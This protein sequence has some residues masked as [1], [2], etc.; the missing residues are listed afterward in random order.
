MSESSKSWVQNE[1]DGEAYHEMASAAV[2]LQFIFVRRGMLSATRSVRDIDT[3][4]R[5][6]FLY[7]IPV[8][9]Q[10]NDAPPF[11]AP[12]IE[13]P[14]KIKARIPS[15]SGSK[16]AILV[17]ENIPSNG[18][19]SASESK[20][21]VFEIWTDNGHRLSNRIMLPC[22]K[23]GPVCTDFA[24]F[25][26]I[27]WSPDESALVYTAEVNTPKT[28]SFFTTPSS[29]TADT[30]ISGGQYT[31][32]VGKS[33]DWGEK[34]SS[35]ALLALFCLNVETGKIG[36]IENVPGSSVAKESFSTEGGY[37]LGQPVFSP[38][39]KTVVYTGWDA[40]AGG[41]MPRRLGAIY[42]FQRPCKIYSSPVSELLGQLG[43][44]SNEEE[45]FNGDTPFYCIT[46]D[47]RLARSPRF[48]KPSG[49]TS[50][51]AYL[52]NTK[53]FDT[54][55]GCM[56]L[57]V[58]D[59]DMSKGL[60]I[61]DSKKCVVDV[62]QLPGERG[63]ET[64]IA[65]IKFPGLWLNQLPHDCFSP[66]GKNILLSTQWGSVTKVVMISL[67]DGTVTPINF[68]LL[69]DEGFHDKASQQFVC[70]TEDGGAIVTQSEAN[71][72]TI[73][74]LLHPSFYHDA[75][76]I[77]P[78][79]VL[80]DMP[81]ISC[82][83]FSL[84]PGSCSKPG[85]GYSY[86]I[87]SKAPIQGILLLPDNSENEKLPL[88]VV[89]HGGPHSCMSTAFIPSYGFLCRYGRYAILLVNY[90]GSSGFG[91]ESLESLAG[92]AGSL[93]V[94]DVVA[95]TRA[96]TESGI[97]DADR[98]GIC[99]GS[100]GGF[101]AGHCIGQHPDIFKVA[102][103]RNPVMNISSMVTATDIPDW[104]YIEALG[105]GHYDFSGFRTPTK[106]ELCIMWDRSPIAHLKNAIAPTLIGLGMKDKRVPP[107][108]GIEYYHALR[109]KHVPTKLLVYNDCD[110]AIDGVASEADF[111]INT[112]RWFDKYLR[113]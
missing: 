4:S 76:S 8:T 106:E 25:G 18:G 80:I 9:S 87:I 53:G 43:N 89:P 92:N 108:Q 45:T 55:G 24:W 98:V 41:E 70:F 19:G 65:G 81:P 63:D 58:S 103:T 7:N 90:R 75:L 78:S 40:G 93:D 64:E 27:S 77:A 110:H 94:H 13:L 105:I 17:E 50:K 22:D 51:L 71:R 66:D 47:D 49:G 29:K 46:P 48:S 38:C 74:G 35:T 96:V 113:T 56:A 52:C 73:L 2:D 39:G 59:W 61:S 102:A 112:K 68:D 86:S 32:G 16:I 72:P 91:Q 107:S 42:C 67:G 88:I 30:Q 84:K 69:S 83:S 28:T 100:H 3:N 57:H 20:R 21:N 109:A 36:V 14:A 82:A 97:V 34:Y 60:V 85:T 5:R 12:P 1:R 26:G 44:P 99:G 37:V 31:L 104:C 15:P 10:S 95:A 23:H 11:I 6:Q 101:L 33:E 54:H 62:V 79:R 111:W